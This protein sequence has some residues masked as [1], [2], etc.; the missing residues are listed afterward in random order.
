MLKKIINKL[1]STNEWYIGLVKQ[2]I[3]SFI[4]NKELLEIEWVV[5]P[6]NI[7]YY[8]DPFF[9]DETSIIFEEFNIEN[10]YGEIKRINFKGEKLPLN[11]ELNSI[12]AHQSFPFIFTLGDKKYCIP[13]MSEFNQ[14]RL[15]SIE[16]DQLT[17]CKTLVE[18]FPGI[19]STLLYIN[20]EFWLF[21]T[22]NE[23]PGS[24]YIFH[25]TDLFSVFTSHQSNPIY[26]NDA[27]SRNA[28]SPLIFQNRIYRP[29]QSCVNFY[30]EAIVIREITV[31]NQNEFIECDLFTIQP[32][33]PYRDGIHTLNYSNGTFVVDGKMSKFSLSTPWRKMK[34]KMN[35]KIKTKEREL[36]NGE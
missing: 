3:E 7:D 12:P 10:G 29:V 21:S 25:S 16:N 33:D 31:L 32:Q 20:D 35:I 15:Y 5:K 19:D 14:V 4:N 13:E 8:A 36:L 30:G 23:Q 18:N 11:G 28:G 27:I 17:Y 34:K 26:M 6:N 2:D 22:H 9:F 1:F 24:L